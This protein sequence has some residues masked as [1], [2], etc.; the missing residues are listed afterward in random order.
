MNERISAKQY[1]IAVGCAIIMLLHIGST[2]ISSTI[3][4]N[5]VEAIGKGMSPISLAMSLGTY[6][7][8]IIGTFAGK[9]INKVTPK[10]ALMIGGACIA[11][12][13]TLFGTA[14]SLP[15]V[16]IG[17]VF[18]GGILTL[19]AHASIGALL[20]GHFGAKAAP[21]LAAVFGISNLGSTI[22][23][24]VTSRLMDAVGYSKTCLYLSWGIFAISTVINLL[25]VRNPSGA[26]LSTPSGDSSGTQAPEIPGMML[27][28][29]FR[30]SSFWLF[31]LGMMLGAMLYAG[32]MTYAVTFFTRYGLDPIVASNYLMA[33][34][35]FGT[36]ITMISG[37]I[38]QRLGSRMLMLFVFGGFII[39]VVFLCLFPAKPAPWM[40]L[41]G[42]FFIAFV[43]PLNALPSLVLPEMFGRKDFT[44]LNSWG[45]S[46]Y[47]VGTGLSVIIIGII[48]DVTGGN[49]VLAFIFLGVMAALALVAFLSALR[50]SPMEKTQVSSE[51]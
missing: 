49:M 24:F 20:S 47:Y 37:K 45:M 41:A 1:S 14:S 17:A 15:P 29:C 10:Y 28:E 33:L 5:L 48:S 6:S 36:A 7:G 3:L 25:L 42:L 39:G 51:P 27:K 8:A 34:T 23:V 4:P 38:I 46:F 26:R 18:G 11:I 43:R 32:I 30:T 12:E 50:A 21:I 22:M 31:G 16:F 9:I 40:A 13:F 35:L 19:G 44:S 2:V